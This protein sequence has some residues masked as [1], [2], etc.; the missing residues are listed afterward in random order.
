MEGSNVAVKT[1]FSS[2]GIE[3]EI[4]IVRA[5]GKFGEFFPSEIFAPK[6]VEFVPNP[7]I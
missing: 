3:I 7:L 1:N 4:E 2:S 5:I 6:K